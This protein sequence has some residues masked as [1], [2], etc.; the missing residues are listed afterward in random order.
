MHEGYS[1]TSK[2]RS[3]SEKNLKEVDLL[4]NANKGDP[5]AQYNLGLL[6]L[7]N[8]EES[9][10]NARDWISRAA[11]QNY[12][13]ALHTKGNM[14]IQ[15]IWPGLNV[16]NG[17]K[18]LAKAANIG[19]RPSHITLAKSLVFQSPVM[20]NLAIEWLRK[21]ARLKDNQCMAMLGKAYDIRG[22]MN[23]RLANAYFWYTLA[24]FNRNKSIKTKL[25]RLGSKLSMKERNQ[26]NFLL[27]SHFNVP[28][29]I[30]E[31]EHGKIFPSIVKS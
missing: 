22:F 3:S 2:Q 26:V 31:H 27:E 19:H 4:E 18:Y 9:L 15:G 25:I 16:I 14:A 8:S 20:K 11:S 24:W 10:N 29:E 6:L 17:R 1:E 21:G 7:S 12:A 30:I 23:E 13:P 5:K 28:I